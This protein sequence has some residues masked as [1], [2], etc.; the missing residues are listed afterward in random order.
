M[1]YVTKCNN[2]ACNRGDEKNGKNRAKSN[3]TEFFWQKSDLKTKFCVYNNFIN[4]KKQRMIF[5]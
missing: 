4:L 3:K 5:L 1:K 2:F